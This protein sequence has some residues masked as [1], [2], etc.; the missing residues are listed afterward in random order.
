MK[1]AFARVNIEHPESGEFQSHSVRIL[2]TLDMLINLLDHP[3][4]LNEALEHLA[5]QHGAQDGITKEHFKVR[6]SAANCLNN[7]NPAVPKMRRG[8]VVERRSLAG[9]LSLS[10]ARPAADGLPLMWVRHP[11]HVS[12]LGQ[13]SLSSFLGR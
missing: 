6:F 7:I 11:L 4:A 8:S 1:D 13:L 2:N 3:S 9:E 5:H 10:C 12:Q